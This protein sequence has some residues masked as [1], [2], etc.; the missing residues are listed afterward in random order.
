MISFIVIGRNE[1]M[2]LDKCFRSIHD[3]VL[4][5][6]I[7][8]SEIIYVDSNSSDASIEIAL[9]NAVDKV[10][11][12][13]RMWNAAMGRNIGA[14]NAS[15]DI[16]CFLDGDMELVSSFIPLI[17]DNNMK[18]KYDLVSGDIVNHYYDQSGNV[19]G[20]HR[21]FSKI[22][23]VMRKPITG[24][25]FWIRKVVYDC[26]GGMDNRMRV[27]EDPELG[28]RLAKK[29]ILLSFIPEI[30]VLHHTGKPK[31][32]RVS[33]LFKG[34]WIYGNILIYKFNILNASTFLRIIRYDSSLI[35]LA[36]SV[37]LAILVHP[38]CF[39]LYIVFVMLRSR[40][41]FSSDKINKF[42]YLVLRDVSV[43]L[44]FIP[45]YKRPINTRSIPYEIIH[46][47]ENPQI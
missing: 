26:V 31:G 3:A 39:G 36:I 28:L 27:S 35:V 32:V 4:R 42:L 5:N 13:T 16:L 20:T 22:K 1:E 43:L 25:A 38:L 30:F 15:G 45:I 8:D 18:L 12:L 10:Y 37:F 41:I 9:S 40:G 2:H 21:A 11:Q 24:G 7:T 23:T 46:E 19:L 44:C 29:G 33:T 6:S 47:P 34:S 17:L 14:M